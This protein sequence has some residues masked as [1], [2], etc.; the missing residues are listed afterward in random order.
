MSNKIEKNEKMNATLR[1]MLNTPPK[2][3]KN[4]LT[5]RKLTSKGDAEMGSQR[6]HRSSQVKSKII[7]SSEPEA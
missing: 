6:R 7:S 2:Q 5:E 3:H 1:R 4:S